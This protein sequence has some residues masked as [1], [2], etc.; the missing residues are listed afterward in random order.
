MK[1][2]NFKIFLLGLFLT[3]LTSSV[4]CNRLIPE[5][6][7][8]FT[9]NPEEE[10]LGVPWGCSF[11]ELQSILDKSPFPTKFKKVNCNPSMTTYQYGGNHRL[12]DAKYSAF[13]F[14]KGKLVDIGVF[15]FSE[16]ENHAKYLF[17]KLKEK[18][19]KELEKVVLDRV[20]GIEDEEKNGVRI[21]HG[22]RGHMSFSLEYGGHLID[23]SSNSVI[24]SAKTSITLKDE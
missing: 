9:G 23:G 3:I 24:L 20:V 4:A 10:F 6:P 1:T 22:T 12:P 21:I 2:L 5:E 15:F 7:M 18:M 8:I 14:W 11:E 13:I 19:K 17:D 16:S